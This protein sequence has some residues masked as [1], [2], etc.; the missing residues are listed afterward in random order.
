M[1]D[2]RGYEISVGDEVAYIASESGAPTKKSLKC[3][4]VGGFTAT[5]VR[6]ANGDLAK[7]DNLIV[8]P[9]A[10]PCMRDGVVFCKSCDN[11]HHVPESKTGWR[12]R[13]HHT[14]DGTEEDISIMGFCNRVEPRFWPEELNK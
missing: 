3:A 14:E 4:V 7:P 2:F 1:V 11:C 6:M 8:L 5:R 12:C 13:L 10:K 9:G